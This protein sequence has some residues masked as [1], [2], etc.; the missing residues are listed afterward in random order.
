MENNNLNEPRGPW[1][2]F[3]IAGF[4]SGIVG[5]ALFMIPIWGIVVGIEGIVLSALGQRSVSQNKKARIGL[6]LSIASVIVGFL[7]V[8]VYFTL[9]VGL[10]LYK[11]QA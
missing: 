7:W 6:G 10:V 3:A 2:A 11:T 5:L 4:V 9:I 1:K 8:F